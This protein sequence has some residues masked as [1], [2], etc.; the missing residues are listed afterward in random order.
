M[1]CS[2]ARAG[3]YA[4]HSRPVLAL[5]AMY[6]SHLLRTTSGESRTADRGIPLS[7]GLEYAVEAGWVKDESSALEWIAGVA[8]HA[9]GTLDLPVLPSRR[10][11]Q[12][13][14]KWTRGAATLGSISCWRLARD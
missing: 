7:Q 3:S 4:P 6:C 8:R 1:L 5:H 12:P 14:C 9:I 2:R 11:V 13:A 10:T